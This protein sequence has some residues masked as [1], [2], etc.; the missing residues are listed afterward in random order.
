MEKEITAHRSQTIA[1]IFLAKRPHPTADL[2]NE[3]GFDPLFK[4]VTLPISTFADGHRVRDFLRPDCSLRDLFQAFPF[5]FRCDAALLERI[6]A[7]ADVSARMAHFYAFCVL[8]SFLFW[9]QCYFRRSIVPPALTSLRALSSGRSESAS[10]LCS[11]AFLDTCYLFVTDDT[12]LSDCFSLLCDFFTRSGSDPALAALE[13]HLECVIARRPAATSL[14]INILRVLLPARPSFFGP[15]FRRRLLRSLQ[16]LVLGFDSL[17]MNF[18]VQLSA[19]LPPEL[20]GDTVANLARSL[21]RDVESMSA[22]FF[23]LP[24]GRV[25]NP[26]AI[27]SVAVF[28]IDY[29]FPPSGAALTDFAVPVCEIPEANLNLICAQEVRSHLISISAVASLDIAFLHSFVDTYMTL[30]Q[31]RLL[32]QFITDFGMTLVCFCALN[33]ISWHEN[34]YYVNFATDFV[35]DPHYTIFDCQDFEPLNTARSIA[36]K[37]ICDSGADVLLEFLTHVSVYPDLLA[38]VVERLHLRLIVFE[39]LLYDNWTLRKEFCF[40]LATYKRHVFERTRV[41]LFRLT[42]ALFENIELCV[43]LLNDPIVVKCLMA[44]ILYENEH[45]FMLGHL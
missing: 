12:D 35:F 20:L 28:E 11:D 9:M 10:K 1:S 16:P 33:Y 41:A 18:F 44:S 32:S 13:F 5:S 30:V 24:S 19:D 43:L 22:P 15:D 25:E 36:L 2:T 39:R 4:D 38:E 34:S 27:A 40:L 3:V 6:H 23:R 7:L 14:L 42:L 29:S 8:H 31:Q 17:A 21:I 45:P 26:K 37:S